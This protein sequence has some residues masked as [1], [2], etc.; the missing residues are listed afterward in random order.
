MIRVLR[1]SSLKIYARKT[2]IECS[3]KLITGAKDTDIRSL[4]KEPKKTRNLQK[5]VRTFLAG[6]G[7]GMQSIFPEE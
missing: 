6:R 5:A 1:E 2:K 3:R 7:R 4:L